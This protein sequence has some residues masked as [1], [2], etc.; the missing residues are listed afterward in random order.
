MNDLVKHNVMWPPIPTK[1]PLDIPKFEGKTREYL[2]AHVTIFH[3]W[4]SSNSLN[5]DTIRLRLFQRN[6]TG[7]LENWYIELPSAAFD[8]FW[9]LTEVFLNHFQLPVR[10]DVG[11]DFLSTF[12]KDKATHISDHIQ[13]WRR[14][15]RLIEANIP[16]N[17]LL[18]W[19][20]KSLLPYIS[21]DVSTSG[22][23]NEDE[24]I[25]RSQQLDL[26]Y[27]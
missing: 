24:S 19:F 15:K 18:D 13:E 23:T 3:L 2:G 12:R 26:I 20:L 17:F 25:L 1:L 5:D 16:A 9:D 8:S 7:V 27:S 14:W 6:I 21:K 4:W 11:T 10:Y 22:V